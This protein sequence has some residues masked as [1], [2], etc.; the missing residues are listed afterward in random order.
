M[1]KTDKSVVF[2]LTDKDPVIYY[3]EAVHEITEQKMMNVI[4]F[5]PGNQK[6]M[7]M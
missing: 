1:F 6:K 3:I 7:S 2:V 5:L 4:G